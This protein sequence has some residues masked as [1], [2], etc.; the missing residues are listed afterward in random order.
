M[1]DGYSGPFWTSRPHSGRSRDRLEPQ[2][3]LRIYEQEKTR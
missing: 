3:A 1:A 2:Q